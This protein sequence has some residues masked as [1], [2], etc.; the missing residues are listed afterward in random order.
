VLGISPD[1]FRWRIL[2]G[3]YPE[4][5]MDGRERT[6]TLEDIEMLAK[7]PAKIGPAK[8]GSGKKVMGKR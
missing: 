6:F 1:L 3:K 2:S 7:V 8:S 4:V 5:K